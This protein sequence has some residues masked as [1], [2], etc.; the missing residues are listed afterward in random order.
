MYKA[1]LEAMNESGE[2]CRYSLVRWY[3]FLDQILNMKRDYPK[4]REHSSINLLFPDQND[5]GYITSIVLVYGKIP[6]YHDGISYTA[7][8][9]LLCV[10][11]PIYHNG[12]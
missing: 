9:L 11:I 2:K 6:I 7:S 1:K 3:R 5:I 8:I 10:K 4:D 12:K